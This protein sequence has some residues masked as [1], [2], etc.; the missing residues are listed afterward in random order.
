MGLNLGRILTSALPVVGDVVGGLISGSAQKKANQQNVALQ[1]EQRA[2]EEKMSNTEMQRRVADLTAAGLNPM[3]AYQNGA[4]TPNVSPAQV[5]T[6]DQQ[7]EGIGTK[8]ATAK[9]A[10]WAAMQAQASIDNT[11]ADTTQ[12]QTAAALNRSLANK[13]DADTDLSVQSAAQAAATTERVHAEVGRIGAE[14]AQI[15][16]NTKLTNLSVDQAEKMNRLLQDAQIWINRGLELGM[17]QKEA[18]AAYYERMGPAAKY[19]QDAGGIMGGAAT[20]AQKLK[21]VFT[22]RGSTML[23]KG[24]K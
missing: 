22:K 15:L 14:T 1:R 10:G 19:I 11:G 18:E 5:H 8:M 3:L 23:P 13:A 2:W 6:T 16:A 4:S 21:D 20:I 12:K 17:P 24:K 9:A 7:W